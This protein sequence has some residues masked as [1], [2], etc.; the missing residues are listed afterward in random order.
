MLIWLWK[1]P[2][3][4]RFR[5]L[6]VLVIRRLG[7]LRDII[8][9]LR[10]MRDTTVMDQI[11]AAAKLRDAVKLNEVSS[12]LDQVCEERHLQFWYPEQKPR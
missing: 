2:Y 10:Q 1:A 9:T 3:G 8:T 12:R 11:T 6:P 4:P 5:T 7:G